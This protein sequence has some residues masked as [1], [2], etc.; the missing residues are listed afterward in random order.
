MAGAPIDF[1]GIDTAVHG[2]VRLGVLTALQAEG[3]LDFTAL[4][5]RLGVADGAIGTHLQKL[6]AAGYIGC[7][8]GFEGRRPKSRYALTEAGRRA[9]FEYLD[10]MQRLIDSLNQ[11]PNHRGTDKP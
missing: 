4:R 2:P 7:R 10:G 8:K 1:A 3:E 11:Q 9:L 5:D 6:E